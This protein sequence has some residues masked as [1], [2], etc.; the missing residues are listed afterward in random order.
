VSAIKPALLILATT[1]IPAGAHAQNIPASAPER[2]NNLTV[3]GGYRFG[4]GFTDVTTG[5][6]WE[7]TE[8]PAFSAALDIGIDRKT[9]WE[10]FISHR[11]SS[12]K[13][14]GFSPV[15]DDIRLGVTYY[16]LGG[17]YFF[18]D[19]GKGGY[20]VGGLGLTNF[21]PGSAGLSSETRFSL[22]VGVGYMIP[23][24]KHVAVKLEGRGYATLVDSTGGFF[25][26]GGCVVQIKGTTFT[27]AEAMAGIA[28][29]F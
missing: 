19:I 15:A 13:A 9:Q 17:T 5:K 7:L 29:R 26:S 23:V 27:Q 21:T 16:H 22:N 4:G 3:Y 11:N 14:S 6:T 2:E 12:L 24:S 28:A 1:A 18:E 25:C 20:V 8:G 10:I